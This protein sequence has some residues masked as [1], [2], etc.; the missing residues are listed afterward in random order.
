MSRVLKAERSR[1][2]RAKNVGHCDVI[3]Y[4]KNETKTKTQMIKAQTF[5]QS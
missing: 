5:S 3:G 4:I 1:K 2:T